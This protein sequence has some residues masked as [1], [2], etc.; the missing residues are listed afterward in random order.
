MD[1]TTWHC[2]AF[3]VVATSYFSP[4]GEWAWEVSVYLT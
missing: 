4:R 2:L 3:A 1:T